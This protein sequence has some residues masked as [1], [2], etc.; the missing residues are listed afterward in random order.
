MQTVKRDVTKVHKCKI[1]PT[2]DLTLSF[3]VFHNELAGKR[4]DEIIENIDRVY[5]QVY[6]TYMLITIPW[7]KRLLIKNYTWIL[8]EEDALP[9]AGDVEVVVEFKLGFD[10]ESTKGGS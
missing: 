6:Y 4:C 10:K 1:F 9:K 7:E 8:S 2:F 5:R 3:Q